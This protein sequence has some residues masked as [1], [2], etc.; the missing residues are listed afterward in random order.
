[1]DCESPFKATTK[2][3]PFS[4]QLHPVDCG[5]WFVI[6]LKRDLQPTPSAEI[7]LSMYIAAFISHGHNSLGNPLSVQLVETNMG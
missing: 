4:G 5:F 3:K 7:R 1:M 2:K 6:A